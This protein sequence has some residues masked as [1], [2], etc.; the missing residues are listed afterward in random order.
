M[1]NEEEVYPVTVTGICIISLTAEWDPPTIRE[2]IH[3]SVTWYIF[4]S[5][6]LTTQSYQ[7]LIEMYTS[8][9]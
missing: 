5:M 3:I 2:T 4:P 8:H 1:I 7:G 6:K 9:D